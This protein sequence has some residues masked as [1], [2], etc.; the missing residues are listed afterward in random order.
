M[1]ARFTSAN[2][3]RNVRE[4][5]ESGWRGALCLNSTRSLKSRSQSVPCPQFGSEDRTPKVSLFWWFWKTSLTVAAAA[6]AAEAASVR[7][8]GD[9]W[10]ERK[11]D[12]L[13]T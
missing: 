11:G 1:G 3:Y 4:K 8:S 7:I 5:E 2:L 10:N 12:H 13:S 6:A 9:C